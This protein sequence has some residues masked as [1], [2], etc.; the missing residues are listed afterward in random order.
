M[1]IADAKFVGGYVVWVGTLCLDSD[2]SMW[3]GML[4]HDAWMCQWCL[5]DCDLGETLPAGCKP[6]LLSGD[7]DCSDSSAVH[8]RRIRT[9]W[10][11]LRRRGVPCVI[12][13]RAKQSVRHK[14][15][16]RLQSSVQQTTRVQIRASLE[17]R[18]QDACSQQTCPAA[19]RSRQH[20]MGYL[21]CCLDVMHI[22]M[23]CA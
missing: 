10:S 7:A 23:H 12:R 13:G 9:L 17:L 21:V 22:F 1:A 20:G 5:H 14:P 18:S 11:T 19:E 2:R 16:A 8:R 4:S 6:V 3:C 15:G